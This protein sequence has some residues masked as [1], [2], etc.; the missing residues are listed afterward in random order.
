MIQFRREQTVVNRRQGPTIK[1]KNTRTGAERLTRKSAAVEGV[2]ATMMQL[3]YAA[4]MRYW[5][6]MHTQPHILLSPPGF[7]TSK[8][9]LV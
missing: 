7:T 2:G 6:V 8:V 3:N 9:Y 5:N 1:H 4:T